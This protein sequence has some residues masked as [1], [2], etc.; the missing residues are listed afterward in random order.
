MLEALNSLSTVNICK[1]RWILRD[2]L[3]KRVENKK[4][5]RSRPT[6]GKWKR[7]EIFVLFVNWTQI[8]FEMWKICNWSMNEKEAILAEC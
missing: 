7:D 5:V 4:P 8:V 6:D 1:T 2:Y 3:Y